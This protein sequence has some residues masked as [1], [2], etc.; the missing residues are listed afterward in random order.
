MK[1]KILQLASKIIQKTFSFFIKNN[2]SKS[3]ECGDNV[4]LGKSNIVNKRQSE[5]I[6]INDNTELIQAEI[7]CYEKGLIS[8]G[9]NCWFSLRTQI[10]ACSEIRI[11]N[12]VIVARDVYI[13]DTNEHPI[14][15]LV[16]RKQ[17]QDYMFHNKIPNRYE[18]ETKPV[19]IGNDVWIGERAFILKGVVIGDGA[20]IAAGSVVTKDV[21][22]LTIVAGNPAKIVKKIECKEYINE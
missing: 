10:I 12:N 22:S 16:R 5:F 21:P 13:S 7:Y 20:V 14:D 19:K 11:G 3:I 8:I 9:R 1:I 15:P 17:T 4:K 2:R 6:S 18:S